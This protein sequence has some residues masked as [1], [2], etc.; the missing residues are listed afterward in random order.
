MTYVRCC[1]H[2]RRGQVPRVIQARFLGD[3]SMV[4]EGSTMGAPTVT[5]EKLSAGE[6]QKAFLAAAETCLQ[7][8]KVDA[9]MIGEVGGGN[10]LEPLSIG[11]SMHR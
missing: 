11:E 10:G 8:K 6:A 4:I 3:D 7:G 1:G 9:V 5:I 2:W